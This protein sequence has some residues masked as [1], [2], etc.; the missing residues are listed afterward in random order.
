MTGGAEV[1]LY[2]VDGEI[3]GRL[4]LAGNRASLGVYGGG[5][6]FDHHD[7]DEAI[8]GGMARVELALNDVV[9]P[10]SQLSAQYKY[11]DDNLRGS[12]HLIG[13]RL[14]IPLGPA[15]AATEVSPQCLR[16]VDR[17]ERDVDIVIAPSGKEAVE[18]A[19]TGVDFDSVL[20]V[21]GGA[22]IDN[23]PGTADKLI[24][25]NGDI[26]VAQT[27]HGDRTL[28][29]GGSTILV[30]G[31]TSGA[32]A[33]FTAPGNGL[34]L[35]SSSGSGLTLTGDNI[36]VA[37]MSIGTFGAQFHGINGGDGKENVFVENVDIS[38]DGSGA[39]GI[40]FGNDNQRIRLDNVTALTVGSDSAGIR[41]G[42]SNEDVWVT[43]SSVGVGSSNEA[44]R[45][46]DDNKNIWVTDNWIP[47]FDQPVPGQAVR[48]GDGNSDV[49]VSGNTIAAQT[50][51][52]RFGSNNTS[53][54]LSDNT[55]NEMDNDVFVFFGPGN[56]LVDGG[57]S[58][59][60]LNVDPGG[61]ICDAN[62]GGSPAGGFA[63]GPLEVTDPNGNLLVFGTNCAPL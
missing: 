54:Q 16:M 42:N 15:P 21:N 12:R 43:N 29:G 3:G 48:F 46:G 5:F 11:T 62:S 55:F 32:V 28:Q 35:F 33:D 18:D 34:V 22:V 51:G 8:T 52:V 23:A 19:W 2:G 63:G 31:R 30:R 14:R 27:L 50:Q 45:F 1:A 58:G 9:G 7:I 24:I 26:Q 38:T 37:G 53:L 41:F 49:W 56:T 36:H 17:I 61:D 57:S 44:V 39:R 6:W 59:N 47:G 60:I 20:Q 25:A 10:G 40:Q 13:A 4:P